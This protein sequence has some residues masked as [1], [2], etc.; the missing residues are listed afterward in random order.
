MQ[1]KREAGKP[2]AR[3]EAKPSGV[4]AL[5]SEARSEAKP[6]GV[7]TGVKAR[8][9]AEP[10]GVQWQGILMSPV[11]LLRSAVLSRIVRAQMRVG[12]LLGGMQS[13]LFAELRLSRT[14]AEFADALGGSRELAAAWLRACHAHGLLSRQGTSYRTRGLARWLA[15]R[16][17][18]AAPARAFLEQA[19]LAYQPLLARI[20]EILRGAERPRW[21]GGK[22]PAR[23]ASA[24][25][26]GEARAFAALKRVPGVRCSRRILDIG[27]GEGAYLAELLRH[28]RDAIGDGVELEPEVAD[29]ARARLAEAQVQRRAEI[30][31]G[32]FT[33][34]DLPHVAFDL[35]MLN[36]NLHYFA[37]SERP[38]LFAR[39]HTHLAPGGVLAILTAFVSDDPLSR[40]LGATATFASFDVF[41]RAHANLSGL[42]EYAELDAEL[43]A[44]GFEAVGFVDVIPGGSLRYVWARKPMREGALVAA[45]T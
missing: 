43:R 18:A 17:P 8:S 28:F 7:D 22:G 6:S 32:D 1:G 19:V 38:A 16:E 37:P 35:A 13:G 42:P 31:V 34:L 26:F 27:C 14:A 3:S 44:A 45:H 15:G 33:A 5:A 2:K 9:E 4:D 41:L 36:Q 12:L 39:V 11:A 21:G 24:S 25:R 23:A 10:S 20:P 40:L 30:H 29:L